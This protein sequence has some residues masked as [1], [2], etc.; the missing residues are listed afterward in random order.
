VA[1]AAVITGG[2]LP[3]FSIVMP[4]IAQCQVII[5]CDGGMEWAAKAG[6]TP[7]Y[8]IGD[9]D[10]VSKETLSLFQ[11][12]GV[13][14][15]RLSP[16]KDDTDTEAGVN[17]ALS[18]GAD[19]IAIIG[20]TGKRLDHSIANLHLLYDLAQKGIRAVMYGNSEE[21]RCVVGEDVLFGAVGQT[22]SVLPLMGECCL[23]LKGFYYP[24]SQYHYRLGSTVGIS[25]VVTEE[26]AK[27][28]VHSGCAF[29]FLNHNN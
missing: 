3:P 20:G 21:V 17:L 13:K 14:E 19:E 26:G 7:H 18:L 22:V 16:I 4:V 12:A 28:T 9:M 23:S 2:E 25:N 8:M 6:I 24:L 10:S 1:K 27:V 11:T 5:A 29:V 15:I